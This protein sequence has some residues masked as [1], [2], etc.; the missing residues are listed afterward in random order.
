M[1][2]SFGQFRAMR[3]IIKKMAKKTI[4]TAAAVGLTTVLTAVATTIGTLRYSEYSSKRDKVTLEIGPT[5][6]IIGNDERTMWAPAEEID[7]RGSYIDNITIKQKGSTVDFIMP[8]KQDY[9]D[10]NPIKI[11]WYGKY[12]NGHLKATSTNQFGAI[13]GEM[14]IDPFIELKK[15]E[16]IVKIK[17]WELEGTLNEKTGELECK[18][19][20]IMQDQNGEIHAEEDEEPLTLKLY[21]IGG[22][23]TLFRNAWGI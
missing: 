2:L 6:N 15:R 12:R 11:R 21:K 19:R 1:T 22:K 17:Q 7:Y 3:T 4:K 14:M 23:D 9:S 8:I 16:D 20:L 13:R 10:E 18:I 5:R